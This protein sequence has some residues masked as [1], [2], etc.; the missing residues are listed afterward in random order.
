M[1]RIS[2]PN[3]LVFIAILAFWFPFFRIPNQNYPAGILPADR[4][5]KSTL[6]GK[7]VFIDDI[8]TGAKL[9]GLI[10]CGESRPYIFD[11]RPGELH[12][13]YRFRDVVIT[14]DKNMSI[15][16]TNYGVLYTYI[17]KFKDYVPIN[18][19]NECRD[20][21]PT[22]T[23]DYIKPIID[24][25]AW[26]LEESSVQFPGIINAPDVERIEAVIV[27]NEFL[28]QT[29]EECKAIEE[30]LEKKYALQLGNE[31]GEL[32]H[33][34]AGSTEKIILLLKTIIIKP[35]SQQACPSITRM[36]W[37][38]TIGFNQIGYPIE[39]LEVS[40]P[41]TP[42]ITD[43]HEH[44]TG[45]QE[46]GSLI[47]EI[48]GSGVA[49]TNMS[50][51]VLIPSGNP[52]TIQVRG[53]SFGSVVVSAIH[54]QG[55]MIQNVS[56]E[57][58]LFTKST[59]SILDFITVQPVLKVDMLNNGSVEAHN[60]DSYEEFPI[61]SSW[62]LSSTP[63]GTGIYLTPS[64]TP[65]QESIQA[66]TTI[67]LSAAEPTNIST[68]APIEKPSEPSICPGIF[69]LAIIPILA[70]YQSKLWGFRR[71]RF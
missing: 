62:Q 66:T 4:T 71:S 45:V 20:F 2:R 26:I 6:C 18:S 38:L 36:T 61:L 32:L 51:Y 40:S 25:S 69:G 49:V 58:L 1:K 53:T 30:C 5:I 24:C 57:G 43:L 7:L 14:K 15:S 22:A 34:G 60:P 54:N 19:C 16:T 67:P 31:L 10:P 35:E 50:I 21:A 39:M 27:D 63:T 70:F 65:T 64:I 11:R 3:R 52:M 9:I 37:N 23:A 33:Q 68:I 56:Y 29:K 46:D 8:K 28:S 42:L 17:S 44:K 59:R 41:A 13:Y 47:E 12:N 55:S 48:P